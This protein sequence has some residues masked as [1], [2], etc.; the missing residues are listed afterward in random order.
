MAS[1][2]VDC[3]KRVDYTGG[4]AKTQLAFAILFCFSETVIGL[5]ES[6]LSPGVVNSLPLCF[7]LPTSAYAHGVSLSRRADLLNLRFV[8]LV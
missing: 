2:G 7:R 4:W 5:K 1:G 3:L 8:C 6:E